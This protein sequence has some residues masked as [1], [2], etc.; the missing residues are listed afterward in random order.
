MRPTRPTRPSPTQVFA[1]STAIAVAWSTG[2]LPAAED[3]GESEEAVTLGQ[4]LDAFDDPILEDGACVE[5][6]SLQTDLAAAV[7]EA[8]RYVGLTPPQRQRAGVV[9]TTIS[10]RPS[11]ER[12]AYD[13]LAMTPCPLESDGWVCTAWVSPTG[14]PKAI[15]T[16]GTIT[17]GVGAGTGWCKGP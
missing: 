2:C 7:L 17:C 13:A 3:D 16:K 6:D 14:F 5:L 4:G 8:R 15:C 11:D 10:A 1:L 12:A 9:T